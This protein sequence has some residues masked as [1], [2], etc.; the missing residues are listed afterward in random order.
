[1]KKIADKK[2]ADWLKARDAKRKKSK[3]EKPKSKK[4][5]SKSTKSKK[6]KSKSIKGCNI[7]G[8]N[9]KSSH[10][11]LKDGLCRLSKKYGKVNITSSCRSAK[12]NRGA[13][14]S[15]HLYSRGCKAADLY[16][17]GVKNSTLRA[18]WAANIGGGRG[19]YDCRRFT[20][21]DVGPNRTWHWNMCK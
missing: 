2:S 18:W 17:V 21:L 10:P 13:P 15:Y 3:E 6:K 5:K 1:M 14:R 7:Q 16:V 4:E 20:H 12:S 8:L 19:T 11:A 9:W